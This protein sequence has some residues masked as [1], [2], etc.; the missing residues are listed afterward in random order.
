M[1]FILWFVAIFTFVMLMVQ[2]RK[3]GKITVQNKNI[4]YLSLLG[5]FILEIFIII[6]LF[7][8]VT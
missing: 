4:Y 3:R 5:L 1:D 8:R 7:L 6:F 2:A